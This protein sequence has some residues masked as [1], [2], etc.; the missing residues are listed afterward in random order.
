VIKACAAESGENKQIVTGWIKA[1]ADRTQAALAPVAEIALGEHGQEALTE[2][3]TT[4]NARIAKI[5]IT[6]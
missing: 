6:L 4:F 5:G 1:W 2:V 3:R